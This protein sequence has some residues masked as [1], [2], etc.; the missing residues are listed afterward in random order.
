MTEF[1]HLHV[2]SDYSLTDASVSTVAL[3]DKAEA[4]GMTHLAL[5]DHGNMFGAMEFIASCEETINEKGE[6]E[7]RKKAIKPII[8]CEVYISPGS[9]F[10]KKGTENENKYYHLILL[11]A[12]REGYFNL[13]KL[14]SLAYTEG[15][16]YRPRIDE[17]I[18]KKY[19]G[20]LIALSA[21]ASGEIP[22]LIQ[23]GKTEE[24]QNKAVYYRDLFGKDENG[25]PC[26][27]LEIMDHGIPE[28]GLRGTQMSQAQ[29]NGVVAEISQRTNIPLV[30]TNDVHYLE[31][32]DYIAHDILLCIGTGKV[33]TE[34]RRKKYHGDQFY[35]KTGDEMAQLLGEY[36]DAI[37]N[38]VRIANR[39]YAD[40]PKIGVKE[41]PNYLPE[42]EIP[43]EFKSPDDYLRRLTNDGLA[44]RYAKEKTANADEWAQIQKRA[45][46]ELDTIINMKFTGYFLIVWDFIRYARENNIPVGPG[47]GSGAGSI[48]AYALRITDIEPLKYGLLFERFLN[49]DRISMPDF[50]IDFA[51]EGREEVIKYVT[52]KYGK[53]RVAQIITFGTLGARAVIKDVAR[54]LGI[55]IPESDM[56]TKLI[57]FGSSLEGAIKEEPKLKELSK[58]TRYTELFKLARKLEGLNRHSSIHA[59]GIVIGKSSLMDF[60][61]LYQERES[62][63]SGKGGSIATQ[64]S[65]NYLE[66]SGLVKM[67]F[68]GL[69]TLDVIKNTQ[70]LIRLRGGEYSNFNIE[71]IPEDNKNAFKMLSEGKSFGI[72]QFESD[73]MQNILKQTKPDS[74]EDLTALNAM[75][76]PGPMQNIPRFV[77]SKNGRQ[78]ITYPDPSLEGI[79]K[80]TYGVIVYQEQVMEVARIIAG[81]SIGQADILRRAMG[82]KVK[83]IL[84]KEKVPFLQGAVKQGYSEK[85]ASAIFDML[86]PFAGY[87]FNKSHAAAYSVLAYQ[88]A[89][90]KANFPAEFMAANLTNEIYS[91][92]KNRLSHCIDE[93]RKMGIKVDPPS[94]NHSGKYFMV[95]QGRIVYGFLGIKGLGDATADEIVRC[96][97]DGPYKSFIDFLDRVDI[98]VTGKKGIE[99]LVQTGAFDEFGITR[100]TLMGNFEKVV[101]Y[102]QKKKEDKLH[103]QTSLFEE[104][105]E[106]EFPDFNFTEYPE[107]SREEKLNNEKKL[108]G[109]YFSGHPMDEYKEIWQRAVNIDLGEPQTWRTGDCVLIGI[110]KKLKTI[111]TSKG[112]KM[113]F[114]VLTD[115]N[116]EIEA[117]FFPSA[118]EKL[119][120]RIENDKVTIL[121]GKIDY[122]KDKDKYTFIAD[123]ILEKHEA[124]NV[125]VPQEIHIRLK[126]DAVEKEENL[127]PLRDYLAENTGSCSMFLHIPINDGEKVVR[128]YSGINYT[129]NINVINELENNVCVEKV[130]R[131]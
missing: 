22:R 65:M 62:S 66:P 125:I 26:F 28:G 57:G 24:A 76:R 41:L 79:L 86:V 38:T 89:Y 93:T 92:D 1:V 29:I 27:Y 6:H 9:R 3:A 106:K 4:L 71:E 107:V 58:D 50:D 17:E 8:G 80:E 72:F 36:P 75:Y 78:A 14:C 43:T 85:K 31:K 88:T 48:V 103:G 105:G 13:V 91:A 104:S 25:E 61:P 113:A 121:K 102:A 53:E 15:F 90:L 128:I 34:E 55:S 18:L 51:N 108:I 131:K 42:F 35:F 32:E 115:Y 101:E 127:F 83:E 97:K 30:A 63:K 82:K 81:Y 110:I 45:E 10:E 122:Q 16:Y 116:G 69:K 19:C 70:D 20:G 64:Y 56:I 54:V 112:S 74:I 2:H 109:F 21:C 87:G 7:K 68:L 47:R 77:E 120:N 111:I 37:A 39:C 59:A 129:G 123:N 124:D 84:D 11:A 94:V 96:R 52:E 60:V 118:W 67:D 119:Q 49:P 126:N 73:G 99:L 100:E 95:V 12:N 5:T 46:Y 44:N 40:V 33:R 130:W 23:A 114:A 98:K 117:T